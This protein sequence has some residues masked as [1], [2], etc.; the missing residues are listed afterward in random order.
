MSVRETAAHLIEGFGNR[1]RA[2]VQ[3]QNGCG[4]SLQLLHHSVRPRAVALSVP[5]ARGAQVRKLAEKGL[6]EIV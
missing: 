3:I 1:A 4:P 5:A 2:Y 6:A